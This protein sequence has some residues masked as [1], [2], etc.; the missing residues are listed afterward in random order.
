MIGRVRLFPRAARRA[1]R[2]YYGPFCE[3]EVWHGRCTGA[4]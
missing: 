3:A 1:R 2:G 4:V